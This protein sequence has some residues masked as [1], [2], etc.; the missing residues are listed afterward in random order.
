MHTAGRGEGA[1]RRYRVSI[2]ETSYFL[3]LCTENRTEGVTHD[4]VASA[5]RAEITSLE[6]D[7]HWS[8]RAGVLMPDHLHLLVKLTGNLSIAR[9]VARLK[10]K[11]RAALLARGLS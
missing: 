11:T 4:D 6:T 3:T 7:G 10:T 2:S 5:I 8:Q 1:L 9:C